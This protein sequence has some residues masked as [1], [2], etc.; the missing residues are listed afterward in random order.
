MCVICSI[1]VARCAWNLTAM[2]PM[3]SMY[4]STNVPKLLQLT[5]RTISLASENIG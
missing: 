5:D 1:N 3:F 4:V 2:K